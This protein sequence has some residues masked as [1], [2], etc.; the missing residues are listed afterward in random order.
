MTANNLPSVKEGQRKLLRLTSMAR[1]LKMD[2]NLFYICAKA[3]QK[4]G[5]LIIAE[6]VAMKCL[7]YHEQPDLII[8][9][10]QCQLIGD[11]YKSQGLLEQAFKASLPAV[12]GGR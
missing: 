11:I 1:F 2:G 10:R 12:S 4:L 5:F 6:Q 8:L 9:A 7:G 3:N